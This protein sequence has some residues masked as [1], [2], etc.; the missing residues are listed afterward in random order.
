MCYSLLSIALWDRECSSHTLQRKHETLAGIGYDKV[1]WLLDQV[2]QVQSSLPPPMQVKWMRLI[3]KLL[4][5]ERGISISP[6]MRVMLL[7][8][9]QTH[10]LVPTLDWG[11]GDLLNPCPSSLFIIHSIHFPF[12]YPLVQ[13]MIFIPLLTCKSINCILLLAKL[14]LD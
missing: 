4:D 9:A 5:I 7:Y 12:S 3:L 14:E 6:V 11:Q 8:L 2:Y 10:W 1:S 13:V